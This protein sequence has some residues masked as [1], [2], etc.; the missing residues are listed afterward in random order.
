[1][2]RFDP[3]NPI[4]N[5]CLRRL[6]ALLSVFC[7]VSV[8][9]AS[10]FD[11]ARKAYDQGRYEEAVA[12][13]ERALNGA[14]G[15]V[16]VLYNLGNARFRQGE[17]GRALAAWRQAQWI[18]PR[19]PALRHNLEL[20]RRRLGQPEVPVWRRWLGWWTLDEW[21]VAAI[22]LVWA[23]SGW[24]ILLRLRPGL[25]DS[26]SG[27]RA[28]LGVVAAV[29][30]GCWWASWILVHRGPNAAIAGNP[31]PA[32]YG[33]LEESDVAVN[34]ADGTEVRVEQS[35]NGW[36]RVVDSEGRGGWVPG[37]KLARY[38]PRIP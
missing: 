20:I 6:L 8:W 27:T 16:G 24:H 31:V 1:M 17:M 14:P 15:G 9:A 38:H 23:W 5:G 36:I 22:V 34:F 7:A 10:E 21:A 37:L 18:T 32:R 30:V 4:R 13:F 2:I 19:D 29:V 3:W 28:M 26:G 11:Q 35:R 33:P 25:S 12:G